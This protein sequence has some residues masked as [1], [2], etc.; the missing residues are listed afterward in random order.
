MAGAG[1]LKEKFRLGSI[2]VVAV[3]LGDDSDNGL[4]KAHGKHLGK[5][6]DIVSAVVAETDDIRIVC[7]SYG[8]TA[9]KKRGI[10]ISL[11]RPSLTKTF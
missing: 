11:P 7:G 2:D 5:A 8:R 1:I 3:R 10:G 9:A 6:A 4:C